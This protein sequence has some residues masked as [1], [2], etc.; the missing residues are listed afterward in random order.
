MP[1]QAKILLVNTAH[2]SVQRGNNREVVF[3]GN[4]DYRYYLATRKEW[5]IELGVKVFGYYLMTNHLH[6]ILD[7]SEEVNNCQQHLK[8][9]PFSR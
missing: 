3:V 6:L 8:T 1:R 4:A 2:H 5:K 7:P 9:A